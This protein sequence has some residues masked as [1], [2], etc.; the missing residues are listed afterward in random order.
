MQI[1]A[2][3][4]LECA[5][6]SFYVGS[7]FDLDRR[8][9]EHNAGAGANY[10]SK[11]RPVKLV[12]WEYYDRVDEAFKRENQVKKWSKAKKIALINKDKNKLKELSKRK[13]R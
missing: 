1:I 6:S 11:R 8:V 2:M 5:D 13:G 10:T 9:E 7:T 3:Y 12:Y 4:I